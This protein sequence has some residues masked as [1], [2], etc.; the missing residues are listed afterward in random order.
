MGCLP[1]TLHM[2]PDAAFRYCMAPWVGVSGI[3][4]AVGRE[5]ENFMALSL[6]EPEITLSLFIFVSFVLRWEESGRTIWLYLCMNL[7]SSLCLFIFISCHVR[8]CSSHLYFTLL[9]YCISVSSLV[10]AARMAAVD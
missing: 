10:S 3:C 7:K 6:H 1:S 8:V 5:W 2:T 9:L 4:L